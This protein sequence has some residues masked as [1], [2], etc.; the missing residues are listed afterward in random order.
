MLANRVFLMAPLTAST[1]PL[2]SGV[3]G[4]SSMISVPRT[5]SASLT[6][7]QEF[8]PAVDAQVCGDA[9]ERSVVIVDE[10]GVA[11]GDEDSFAAGALWADGEAADG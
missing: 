1:L 11:N 3:K 6:V 9:A 5:P 10:D 2:P 7:A 8:F 4:G